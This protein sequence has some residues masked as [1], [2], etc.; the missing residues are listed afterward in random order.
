MTYITNT[1]PTVCFALV[2]RYSTTHFT[3][4]RLDS[5]ASTDD[6]ITCSRG[7]LIAREHHAVVLQDSAESIYCPDRSAQ[8]GAIIDLSVKPDEVW[9][10]LLAN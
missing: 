5:V 6:F 7:N 10:S 8:L 4:Q 2:N 1:R 3:V 9:S